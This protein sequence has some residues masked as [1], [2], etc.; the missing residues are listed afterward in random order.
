MRDEIALRVVTLQRSK[1]YCSARVC[2]PSTHSQ[3]V[4]KN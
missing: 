4:M 2:W 3:T 1:P